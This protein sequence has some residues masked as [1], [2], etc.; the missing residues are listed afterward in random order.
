M[1][2]PW[3]NSCFLRKTELGRGWS[4]MGDFNRRRWYVGL[5]WEGSEGD[6]T[7]NMRH[8][9]RTVW[10]YLFCVRFIFAFYRGTPR[11]ETPDGPD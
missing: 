3:Q 5:A 9:W 6:Q 11:E 7:S 10:L 1:K 8:D 4:V 2:R